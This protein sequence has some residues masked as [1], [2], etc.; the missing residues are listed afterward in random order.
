MTSKKSRMAKCAC[1]LLPSHPTHTLALHDGCAAV[2]VVRLP[3]LVCSRH[4]VIHA[5]VQNCMLACIRDLQ[6]QLL[7][8]QQRPDRVWT[9]GWG[10]KLRFGLASAFER[11]QC[12]GV[13]SRVHAWGMGAALW[14]SPQPVVSTYLPAAPC[15]IINMDAWSLAG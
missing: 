15:I 7:K 11:Q 10:L 3:M 9:Q 4:D 13:R 12:P 1:W 2:H 8:R 14:G 6:L 5:S